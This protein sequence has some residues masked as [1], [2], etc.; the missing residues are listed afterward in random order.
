MHYNRNGGLKMGWIIT[1]IVGAIIG[2]IA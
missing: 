2:A 1:L